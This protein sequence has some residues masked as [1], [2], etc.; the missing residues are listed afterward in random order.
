M[1][2]RRASGT[3]GR[4]QRANTLPF[5]LGAALLLSSLAF[6]Q[7]PNRLYLDHAEFDYGEVGIS[8]PVAHLY[9]HPALVACIEAGRGND[10]DC[11]NDAHYVLPFLEADL[12]ETAVEEL[13]EAY[14]N[15][16]RGIAEAVDAEI[17]NGPPCHA[18]MMCLPGTVTPPVPDL[19]CLIPRQ[20][21]GVAKGIAEHMPTYYAEV[22]RIINTRLGIHIRS[23]AIGGVVAPYP[24]IDSVVAP[25]MD[26]TGGL[27]ELLGDLTSLKDLDDAMSTAY[28]MQSLAF[29]AGQPIPLPHL[30]SQIEYEERA[31]RLLALPGYR[32]YEADKRN[33]ESLYDTSRI[34]LN[35]GLFGLGS[36]SLK[37]HAS[38]TLANNINNQLTPNTTGTS[39]ATNILNEHL[40]AL[41]PADVI[42]SLALRVQTTIDNATPGENLALSLNNTLER[43]IAI[44]APTLYT[45]QA[46][47]EPLAR[48]LNW[49]A[50]TTPATPSFDLGAALTVSNP[51]LYEHIGYAGFTQ[52]TPT[53]EEIMLLH[54]D[55]IVPVPGMWVKCFGVV[56][57]PLK[58]PMPTPA[59]L[60]GV[61]EANYITVPEGYEVPET[62]QELFPSP[63]VLLFGH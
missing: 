16:R 61:A 57:T 2:N 37:T 22:E 31:G 51:L 17:N 1:S 44:M 63:A 11:T 6:A 42:E 9:D 50:P 7:Q 54:W 32:D 39:V 23:G 48:S 28:R 25:T 46:T 55:G 12:V 58:I 33:S 21:A 18:F 20:V 29:A 14:R 19:S 56:P 49:E 41:V 60:Y 43:G 53:E 5:L 24:G 59:Y 3:P 52:V 62:T 38:Q 13:T 30:A 26:F 36:S 40:G 8:I 27:S 10:P 45:N 35:A 47:A 4:R 34:D 15:M